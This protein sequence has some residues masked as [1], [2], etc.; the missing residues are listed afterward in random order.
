M[1]DLVLSPSNQNAICHR[2]RAIARSSAS[3]AV[4]PS[5]LSRALATLGFA[6]LLQRFDSLPDQPIMCPTASYRP[7]EIPE[8]L[9]EL[10]NPP[11]VHRQVQLPTR[12]RWSGPE[13]T[14]DLTNRTHRV[15]VYKQVLLEGTAQDIRRWV[16]LDELIAL[17]DD[18]WLP[19][20][21]KRAW[22]QRIHEARNI[23]LPC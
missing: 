2:A 19:T 12:I 9:E 20:E 23:D 8:D 11:E 3:S 13:M 18:L 5:A 7:F 14:Y 17:W 10:H 1:A 6:S 4:T 15:S 22:A 16:D 21:L